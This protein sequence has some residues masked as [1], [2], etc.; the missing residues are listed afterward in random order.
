MANPKAK[1]MPIPAAPAAP[2]M[3]DQAMRRFL[4]AQAAER[5]F[6][7]G[8]FP[9]PGPNQLAIE[10]RQDESTEDEARD[11]GGE[12]EDPEVD[13]EVLL[14]DK[15]L[16]GKSVAMW[17]SALL[18]ASSLPAGFPPRPPGM[19]GFPS[20]PAAPAAEA[21]VIVVVDEEEPPATPASSSRRLRIRGKKHENQ[22]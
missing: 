12:E 19:P 3:P 16:F 2:A 8:L 15:P 14:L 6:R 11:E 1:A 22:N 18:P 20:E 13:E 5:R 4:A 9:D 10:D 21:L 17:A 7:Q